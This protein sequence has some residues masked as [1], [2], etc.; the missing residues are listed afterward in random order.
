[1][2]WFGPGVDRRKV[3]NLTLAAGIKLAQDLRGKLVI[4][5]PKQWD[6]DYFAKHHAEFDLHPVSPH[7]A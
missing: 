2:R 7:G 4:L 5:F 3:E 6:L 1:V